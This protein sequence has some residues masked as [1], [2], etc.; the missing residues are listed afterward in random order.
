MKIQLYQVDAFAN[1]AFQGNPAAVC[2]LQAWLPDSA[3][4]AIAEENNLSETA[5]FIPKG[6]TF[7]IRWFTPNSEV[8]LCGHATL[9][10]AFVIF[11]NGL[12]TKPTIEFASRSGTLLAT[13]DGETITIDFP[14]QGG[15]PCSTPETL[16]QALG[17]EPKECIRSADYMAVFAS[18]AEIL[19]LSPDFAL[20]RELDLRGVIV[21]APGVDTDFVSR[22]FAP[23]FGIDED[24]VTG[25]AHCC[26][27]PYWARQ[28]K[29][30]MLTAR[31]LSQRTGHLA[32]Q[33][34]DDR[35]LISGRAILYLE[36]QI[37][38]PS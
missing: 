3:L 9:A 36:G 7:D 22:F 19:A 1:A 30:N 34:K 37:S 17:S 8:D 35:I 25:S 26:L 13:Q 31:Q 23:K 29:K 2:P 27:A 11:R 4:Q 33:L 15:T 5:F 21:T 20:M 18:Q 12:A 28:L 16:A 6:D 38:I 32:C 10:T 14:S 24:P